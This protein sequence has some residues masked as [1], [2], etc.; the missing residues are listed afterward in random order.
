MSCCDL[1]TYTTPLL[2]EL[3]V[4]VLYSLLI[5]SLVA[6]CDDYGFGHRVELVLLY[7]FV[8]CLLWIWLLDFA[9]CIL[10]VLLDVFIGFGVRT[11]C[12]GLIGVWDLVALLWFLFASGLLAVFWLFVLIV[13]CLGYFGVFVCVLFWFV[14]LCKLSFWT[15]CWGMLVCLLWLIVADFFL[16]VGLRFCSAL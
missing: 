16:V 8:F 12:L 5:W 10:H 1:I 13:I 4:L 14:C 2:C 7:W 11:V 15:G 9:S 3:W 6:C